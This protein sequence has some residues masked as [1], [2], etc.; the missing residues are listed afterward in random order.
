M[1]EKKAIGALWKKESKAGNVYLSG[2]I[3]VNGNKINLVVFKNNYKEQKKH[4]DY[5]IYL[6]EPLQ[7]QNTHYQAKANGYSPKEYTSEDPF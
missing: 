4:P 5:K 3:E 7:N 6:S 1:S 2:Q